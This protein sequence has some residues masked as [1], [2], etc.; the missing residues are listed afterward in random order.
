VAGGISRKQDIRAL[1]NI[2]VE[3]A[4]LGSALYSGTITLQEALEEVR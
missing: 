2:G 4:V 3:G 1:K